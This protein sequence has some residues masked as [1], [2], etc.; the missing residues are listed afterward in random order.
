[1]TA[2]V[3]TTGEAGAEASANWL[4]LASTQGN[5]RLLEVGAGVESQARGL[6]AHFATVHHLDRIPALAQ[7]RA[8]VVAEPAGATTVR[9]VLWFA[10]YRDSTF[11][12]VV[13]G[14]SHAEVALS[15][16][17]ACRSTLDECLRVLRPGGC[18]CVTAANPVHFKAL[19]ESLGGDRLGFLALGVRALR[20]HGFKEVVAYYVD[21]GWSIIPATRR[22]AR[23]WERLTG[24]PTLHGRLRR[25]AAAMGFHR[26]IHPRITYLAYK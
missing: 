7:A 3:G 11:D 13:V 18:L 19:R 20:Q 14:A 24:E 6:A 26:L 25:L 5:E 2:T 21:A 10:P 15:R 16:I 12:C 8:S 4:W 9:G 17:A 1:V 23:T 22:S